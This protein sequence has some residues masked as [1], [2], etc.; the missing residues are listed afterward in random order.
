MVVFQASSHCVLYMMHLPRWKLRWLGQIGCANVCKFR[1]A[2][3]GRNK[4]T[5]FWQTPSLP[6]WRQW[7]ACHYDFSHMFPLPLYIYTVSYTC[8][9]VLWH[10]FPGTALLLEVA[11]FV[12][13]S[14][15]RLT[16]VSLIQVYTH[17]G[18]VHVHV[19]V[20]HG[21]VYSVL[22]PWDSPR[23]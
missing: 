6:H 9:R 16:S 19:L 15:P 18:L 13:T 3:K 23:G 10:F 2:L 20:G 17:D 5:F 7:N 21:D 1:S 11:Q 12:T 4:Y 22:Q 8:R 14:E